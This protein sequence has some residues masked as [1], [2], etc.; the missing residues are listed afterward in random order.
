MTHFFSCGHPRT[1]ENTLLKRKPRRS[2]VVTYHE[3]R[4]CKRAS[5]RRF[6]KQKKRRLA[7]KALR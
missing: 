2:G 6:Y 3:C 4:T 1:L 7:R 5:D